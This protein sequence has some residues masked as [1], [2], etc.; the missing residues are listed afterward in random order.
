[1]TSNIKNLGLNE[2]NKI[3]YNLCAY[4]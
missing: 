4:K 1:M 3:W 2:Y